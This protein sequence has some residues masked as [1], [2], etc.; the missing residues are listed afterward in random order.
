MK[1]EL[2]LL[3]AA[4]ALVSCGGDTRLDDVSGSCQSGLT[5]C[6]AGPVL[7]LTGVVAWRGRPLGWRP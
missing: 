1:R 3:A 5:V 2:V 6:A 4:G 7:V